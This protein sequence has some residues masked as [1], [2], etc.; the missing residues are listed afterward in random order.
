MQIDKIK[1]I[2]AEKKYFWLFVALTI[3]FA[4]VLIFSWSFV[5]YTNFYVRED[6][7]TPLNLILLAI[8]S[9]LSS[10]NITISLYYFSRTSKKMHGF[11]AIIPSFFTTVCPSCAPLLLSFWSTTVVVWSFYL[12]S[13]RF[14]LII[15]S[16]IILLVSLWKMLSADDA[17]KV[18]QNTSIAPKR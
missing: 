11:L 16:I 10:L 5:L 18:S 12:V 7:W 13:F 17:C 6:L 3:F 2:L 9:V 14:Y 8:T 1:S 4:I 15:A